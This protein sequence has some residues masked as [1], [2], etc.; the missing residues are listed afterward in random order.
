MSRFFV[1]KWVFYS[2]Y[3]NYEEKKNVW[4]DPLMLLLSVKDDDDVKSYTPEPLRNSILFQLLKLW[5]WLSEC[6]VELGAVDTAVAGG[7][8]IIFGCLNIFFLLLMIS[9]F[10]SNFGW[11]SARNCAYPMVSVWFWKKFY[12]CC[13]CFCGSCY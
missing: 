8:I 2:S 3:T 10:L 12:C 13:C 4:L 6:F 5:W 1:T 7:F 9:T 11:T